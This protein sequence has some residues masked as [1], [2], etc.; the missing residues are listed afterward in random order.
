MESRTTI[1]KPDSETLLKGDV[2]YRLRAR[3]I[4]LR[5]LTYSSDKGYTFCKCL[6]LVANE[7]KTNRRGRL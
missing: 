6:P 5:C 7:S 4:G 2:V 1:Y 3:G